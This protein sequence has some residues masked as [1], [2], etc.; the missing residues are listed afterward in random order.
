MATRLSKTGGGVG[1]KAGGRRETAAA[2]A[3]TAAA[4]AAAGAGG[5]GGARYGTCA[6]VTDKEP[7]R[8]ALG[9]GGR[10]FSALDVGRELSDWPERGPRAAPAE[11][12]A[13]CPAGCGPALTNATKRASEA[14]WQSGVGGWI[15]DP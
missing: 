3:T 4:A 6:A 8:F 11:P 14:A 1:E 13:H 9:A 15:G 5:G 7:P 10:F 12:G 2:G